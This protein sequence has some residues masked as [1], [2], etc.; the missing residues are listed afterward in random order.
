MKRKNYMRLPNGFGCIKF[1]GKNRR[2]QYAALKTTGWA[3][4][5]NQIRKYVGYA[6]T[7]NE[8]YQI[9][10]NYS[11]NPF[12]IDKKNITLNDI[13][14]KIANNLAIELENGKISKSTYAGLLSAWNKQLI[15]LK[16]I[17]I[18]ELKKKDIQNIID[19]SNLKHTGRTNIKTLASKIILYAKDEYELRINFDFNEI[20][21]GEK[22]KSNKHKPFTDEEVRKIES[23]AFNSNSQIGK[24]LVIYF[25][26]G[27]RPSELLQIKIKN[28]FLTENYMIGG[29]KTTAGKNRIIPIHQNIKKFIQEFYNQNKDKEYLIMN[30]NNNMTY[31]VYEDRFKKFM[32]ELNMN[33]IPH[34]TRH[35]FA[36]KLDELNFSESIIKRLMGHSLSNDVT[37]DVYIHKSAAALY[38]E[39]SKLKY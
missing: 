13:Y 16:D 31:D 3:D 37:N 4:N 23:F 9:L 14:P 32:V 22:E 20:K 8:A 28:V 39:I 10:L 26:T 7:Y 15:A 21:I 30:N 29:I 17:R 27:L 12:N 25:Y 6:E 2:N 18:M 19:K 33:H 5:G 36:T 34:D 35:T 38:K 24:M 1:L 11:T